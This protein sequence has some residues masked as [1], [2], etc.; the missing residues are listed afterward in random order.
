MNKILIVGDIHFSTYSSI[1]R[2]RGKFYSSRIEN[3][4]Q[5]IIWAEKLATDAGCDSVVFLGDAFDRPELGSEEITALQEIQWNGL[6]HYVLCGNHEMGNSNLDYTSA[7][8]FNLTDNHFVIDTPKTLQTEKATFLFLPYILN[9]DDRIL[10]NFYKKQ[11][12]NE[13]LIVFSHNDL[14]GINFGKITSTEGF[15][16]NEIDKTC[17]YYFNGHLHNSGWESDVVCNV[18][19]LTGQ[20]FG[21]DADRW[22]HNVAILDVD[23]MTVQFIENPYAY[24][25]YKRDINSQEDIYK[26]NFKHNAIVSFRCIESLVNTLRDQVNSDNNI[27]EYRIV[28]IPEIKADASER[29]QELTAIDH[30]QQFKDYVLEQIENTDILV[31]ELSEIL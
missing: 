30:L 31:S 24:N 28:S 18:G 4:I 27:S 1:I 22:S 26:L 19:N 5:S 6:P 20:N 8:I 23:S 21:E 3:C 11:H 29:L 17:K 13:N 25:F 12:P 10:S 15:D 9:N 7:H 2:S 14:K 16:I